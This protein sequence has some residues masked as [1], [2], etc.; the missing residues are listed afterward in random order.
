MSER[1][2]VARGDGSFH[3]SCMA[4]AMPQ[5]KRTPYDSGLKILKSRNLLKKMTAEPSFEN[6][7][8]ILPAQCLNSS[9]HPRLRVCACQCVRGCV[10]VCVRVC[11]C[12][13]LCACVCQRTPSILNEVS[14]KKSVCYWIYH[15]NDCRVDF[16][17]CLSKQCLR[18]ASQLNIHLT[19]DNLRTLNFQ[20][21][22]PPRLNSQ[23]S[24]LVWN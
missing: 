8:Q 11:V 24:C 15:I 21:R 23:K 2:A 13:Y 19:L 12:A 20:R 1:A 14:Q 7:L 5:C 4:Y 9:A 6:F 3:I 17:E 18:N 22:S 16:W 10:Y